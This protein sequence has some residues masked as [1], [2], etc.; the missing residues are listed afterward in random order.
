MISTSMKNV[1]FAL[2]TS[3]MQEIRDW[4]AKGQKPSINSLVREALER[5]LKDV[6]EESIRPDMLEASKD[7]LFLSASPKVQN[8]TGI[9]NSVGR[10]FESCQ[11]PQCKR[12]KTPPSAFYFQNNREVRVQLIPS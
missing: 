12:N 1:T 3:I 7:P 2:P 5:Y 8:L 6:R 10:T 11:A 9:D 4:V